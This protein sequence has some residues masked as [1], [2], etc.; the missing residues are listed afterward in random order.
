MEI[1]YT[2]NF[3]KQFN[4]CPS[5]IQTAFQKRLE[6]FIKNKN[7]PILRNHRLTG[8]LKDYKSIN[9]TGDWRALYRECGENKVC[10]MI[11]G[12]HSQL[13]N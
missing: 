9:I 6:I 11:I 1:Q 3:I 2:K 13:Y 7:Y 4:K 5:Q 8:L 10:F 12:T